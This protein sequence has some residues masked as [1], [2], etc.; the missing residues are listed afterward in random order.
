[1]GEPLDVWKSKGLQGAG[2]RD[3]FGGRDSVCAGGGGGCV[4]PCVFLCEG[5]PQ[6]ES[7]ATPER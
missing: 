2:Q 3:S 4:F 6:W 7:G 5:E 1:M